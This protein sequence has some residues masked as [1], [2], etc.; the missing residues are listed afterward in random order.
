MSVEVDEVRGFLAQHEPFAHLPEG[1][2]DALSTQLKVAYLR[3]G[4]V[5][6]TH[7]A[8]NSQLY[9]I[10][11]GA[12]DVLGADGILLDRREEGLTFGYSTLMGQPHSQY[13]MIAVED[14]LVF[15]LPQEDFTRLAQANP[16]IARFFSAQNRQIRAAAR[17]LAESAPSDALRTPIAELIRPNPLRAPGETSTARAAQLMTKAKVSSLLVTRDGAL[18]GIVTDRDLR[19]RVLAAGVDPAT[20]V[21]E[22]MTREL[23]TVSPEAPAMEALLRMAEKGIHH[24]PVLAGGAL[25]GII[26]QSD[27]ARLL[28]NDPVYLAADLSRRASVEE[29]SGAFSQATELAGRY[30][31]RGASPAEAASLVTMAADAV[32]RRLCALAEEKLGAP[33]VDY[34]LVA[35]GSQARREMALASD[36]DNALVLADDFDEARHGEYFSALGEF[37]C[38]GLAA[39]GQPLCPG[40]MMAMSPQW[41]MT[42]RQWEA[43]FHRWITDPQPEAL[44]HAQVFFDFRVVYGNEELGQA[45]HR[46]AVEL[47]KGSR[48]LHAHL[49]TLAVRRE[50][51]LTIFRGLVV[52]RDGDYAN[53][54]DIKKGG[55][56]G[57]VQM[58]RL[59]ALAAGSTVVDTRQRLREA[60]GTSVSEAGAQ[61]LLDAFDFLRSVAL[62]HQA[63]QLRAGESP[64]YHI[65]PKS[66]GR[67]EREHLRDAFRAVKSMQSGLATLYPVRNI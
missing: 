22:I 30:I 19:T 18:E 44:L 12:V 58:A 51:P 8:V 25:E 33:P 53:T 28:H 38:R 40:E 24:L 52:E 41:R 63:R 59:F 57:I 37:L 42:R 35:V 50:P 27:V 26:T 1:Q 31:E 54:L 65:D 16:D 13:E 11:T 20:P 49:A 29:L 39:A 43:T 5:P 45:V 36:Q 17:E 21:S 6:I 7:G 2:L 10:R 55:T 3:R 32:A 15:L 4:E 34:A 14:S 67:M 23:A 62:R 61:E 64:D 56:A 46:T 48:R 66:L 47:G 60:A 9:I